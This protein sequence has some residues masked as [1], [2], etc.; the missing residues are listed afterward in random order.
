LTCFTNTA[1]SAKQMAAVIM[2]KIP[3]LLLS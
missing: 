2:K 1:I 3:A